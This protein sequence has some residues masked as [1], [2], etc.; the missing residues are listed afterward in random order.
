MGLG[1]VSNRRPDS[2]QKAF[3]KLE[4]NY[5]KFETNVNEFKHNFDWNIIARQ[6]YLIYENILE[7]QQIS[8][9]ISQERIAN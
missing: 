8:E 3:V 5:K 2:F 4:K 1:I 6:H 7:K 9:K